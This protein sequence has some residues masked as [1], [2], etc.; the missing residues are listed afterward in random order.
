MPCPPPGDLPDPGVETTSPVAPALQADSLPTEPL[1]KPRRILHSSRMGPH[2]R[3]A[4]ASHR[5]LTR[6]VSRGV[7]CF[8]RSRMA[9]D[10]SRVF[11]PPRAWGDLAAGLGVK[12]RQGSCCL[13]SWLFSQFPCRTNLSLVI[14]WLG[15]CRPSAPAWYCLRLPNIWTWCPAGSGGRLDLA[16]VPD[17]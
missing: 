15:L 6:R 17:S 7:G 8:W 9:S 2:G 14:G 10:G 13:R 16:G 12:V 3:R 5:G 1:G 4:T 11:E